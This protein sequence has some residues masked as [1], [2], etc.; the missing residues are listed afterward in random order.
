MH[1]IRALI[2]QG[3]HEQLDFK[4]EI[5]S[6]VKIAKTMV[7]FANHKGGR[8]LVGIR[9]NGAVAGVRT[10]DEKYMLETASGF[11]CKP[12]IH[13]EIREWE[14]DGKL[15]L[16]AIVPNGTNKPYLALGEDKKWWAYIRVKDKSLLASKVVVDVLRRA[17]SNADVFIPYG[18]NE[19]S[20]IDYLKKN[21][22]I[23]IQGFCKLVN[24]SRR[25]ANRILVKLIGAGVIRS[26]QTEKI[27]HYTLS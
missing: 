10:E 2:Q 25:R 12:E 3:E 16:E 15:V 14:L 19:K 5:S 24:I 9:D 11:Y 6:A 21:E 13:L 7:S 18:H 20:L 22:R 26:H 17:Q 8:L 23:T 1:P 27:E 4:Q